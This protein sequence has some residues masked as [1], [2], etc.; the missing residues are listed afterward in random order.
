VKAKFLTRLLV[1]VSIV[2]GMNTSVAKAATVNF[3][4]LAD[5][6][7][8]AAKTVKPKSLEAVRGV[9]AGGCFSSHDG[10]REMGAV[11]VGKQVPIYTGEQGEE[12]YGDSF[13]YYTASKYK[14]NA[15]HNMSSK[16]ATTNADVKKWLG[17]EQWQKAFMSEEGLANWYSSSET[18]AYRRQIKEYVD[19]FVHTF[20][21]KSTRVE[22]AT[23]TV[24]TYCFFN[25]K[26]GDTAVE[27][28][29][30]TTEPTDYFFTLTNETN[31]NIA[32]DFR[33]SKNHEWTQATA[34]P[35]VV[36]E[37]IGQN[38]TNGRPEIRYWDPYVKGW[39]NAEVKNGAGYL[40][41]RNAIG[42]GL[43]EVR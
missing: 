40:L 10:D 37:L 31:R 7:A 5:V 6:F 4:T 16:Q 23:E 19:P 21:L 42:I 11:L 34:R 24:S 8:S 30:V 41:R 25:K 18:V 39:A 35:F 32:F 15:F 13:T 43:F 9:W 27:P 26:L 28:P 36:N 29:P 3:G 2:V 17:N 12:V 33:F 14:A 22:N 38:I 1:L 20:I